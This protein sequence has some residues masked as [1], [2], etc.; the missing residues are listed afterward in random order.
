MTV[1]KCAFREGLQSCKPPE[2]FQFYKV[3]QFYKKREK[4]VGRKREIHRQK[5]KS[6]YWD[7]QVA[8]TSLSSSSLEASL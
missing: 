8:M 2:V 4:E 3:T 1:R 7:S 5:R 6:F